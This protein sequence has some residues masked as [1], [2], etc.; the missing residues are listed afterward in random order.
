MK[1]PKKLYILLGTG[2]VIAA[3]VSV[4]QGLF[5]SP[6]AA[7][8]LRHLCDGCFVAALLLLGSGGLVWTYSGG[9]LDGLGFSTKTL[10]SLKWKAFGDYKESFQEYRQRRELKNGSPRPY[11]VAGGCWLLVSV[12]LFLAYTLVK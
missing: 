10:L 9:V 12:L 5:S 1:N 11:L 6:S 8:A 2:F 4:T 3:V 7:D